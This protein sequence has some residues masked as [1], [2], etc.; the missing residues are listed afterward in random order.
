MWVDKEQELNE[1]NL[2]LNMILEKLK[3][4]MELHQNER[5]HNKNDEDKLRSEIREKVIT[6]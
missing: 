3:V 1:E 5:D 4:E 2:Q 6:L